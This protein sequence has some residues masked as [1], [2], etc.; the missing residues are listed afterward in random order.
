MDTWQKHV[1]TKVLAFI[2]SDFEYNEGSPEVTISINQ[3]EAY[4]VMKALEDQ[5]RFLDPLVA[6]ESDVE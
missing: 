1:W 3:R 2:D 4:V 6:T 5:Q